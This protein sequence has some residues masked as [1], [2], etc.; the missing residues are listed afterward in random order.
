MTVTLLLFKCKSPHIIFQSFFK[1]SPHFLPGDVILIYLV[2]PFLSNIVFDAN[3]EWKKDRLEI[4]NRPI[5]NLLHLNV[6]LYDLL[7]IKKKKIVHI[8][9]LNLLF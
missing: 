7:L 2:L 9:A 8:M 5:Q 4:C 3:I 1:K 6:F